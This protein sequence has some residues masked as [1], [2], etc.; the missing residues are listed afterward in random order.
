MAAAR[1][2]PEPQVTISRAAQ[3]GVMAS[4][5]R[6]QVSFGT[7]TAQR[8]TKRHQSFP[9]PS[10]SPHITSHLTFGASHHLTPPHITYFAGRRRLRVT[11]LRRHPICPLWAHHAGSHVTQ[12]S[13]RT[14]LPAPRQPRAPG[15][16]R[17]NDICKAIM[18]TCEFGW[19]W[20]RRGCTPK[21]RPLAT[22]VRSQPV[23]TYRCT[24]W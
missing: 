17:S 4:R 15:T 19:V 23:T 16:S 5:Q 8:A 18:C 24:V 21:P 7:T 20:R 2:P 13:R 9:T 10:A 1:R 12:C 6:D 11:T 22:D 3:Y 14:P